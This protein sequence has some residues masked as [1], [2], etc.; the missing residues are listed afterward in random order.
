LSDKPR[1]QKKDRDPAELW[2][3]KM[4]GA[5]ADWWDPQL[6]SPKVGKKGISPAE[7]WDGQKVLIPGILKVERWVLRMVVSRAAE[8]DG[9]VVAWTAYSSVAVLA[10]LMDAEWV[11]P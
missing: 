4:G 1:V 2:D 9:E 7:K 6:A 8:M 3:D 5:T 11:A 10:V